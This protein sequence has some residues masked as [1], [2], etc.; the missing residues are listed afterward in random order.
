MYVLD[1][2]YLVATVDS[3]ECDRVQEPV[4]EREPGWDCGGGDCGYGGE[5]NCRC[6]LLQNYGW[7]YQRKR[8]L[9][10]ETVKSQLIESLM[11][12][13][14]IPPMYFDTRDTNK[15]KIIDSLQR[16]CTLA[17]GTGEESGEVK[18]AT[19]VS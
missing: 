7:K 16:L 2:E 14:P 12:Q 4:W 8:S 6:D 5:Y 11:I 18:T 3:G 13:L 15:W 1:T 19:D 17:D 9:W 10:T